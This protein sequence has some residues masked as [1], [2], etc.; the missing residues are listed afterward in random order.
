MQPF[1][2]EGDRLDALGAT[3]FFRSSRISDSPAGPPSFLY[4]FL[5]QLVAGVVWPSA[6]LM[7]H[8]TDALS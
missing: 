3:D 5:N 4:E 7:W 6:K 1:L 2:I 8:Q